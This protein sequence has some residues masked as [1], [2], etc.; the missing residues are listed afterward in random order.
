MNDGLGHQSSAVIARIVMVAGA[1]A[2]PDP[3]FFEFLVEMIR[4]VREVS[5]TYGRVL[6]ETQ[7]SASPWVTAA[8]EAPHKCL[9]FSQTR[10]KVRSKEVFCKAS[11]PTLNC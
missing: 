11:Y 5:R 3:R 2:Y 9:K 7:P 10:V 8:M 4:L 6:L 1:D